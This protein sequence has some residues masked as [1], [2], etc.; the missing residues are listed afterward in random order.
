MAKLEHSLDDSAA[1]FVDAV[2]D[3]VLFDLAYYFSK[4]WWIHHLA[5]VDDDLLDD[6]VSMEVEWTLFDEAL[7]DNFLNHLGVVFDSKSVEGNLHDSASMLVRSV[8]VN[9]A[10]DV[11]EYDILVFWINLCHS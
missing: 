8:F 2:S 11:I 6:V 7:W 10:D 9:I 4:Y 1:I 5:H 3:D